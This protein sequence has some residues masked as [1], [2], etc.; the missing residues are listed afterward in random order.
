MV[1]LEARDEMPAWDY[2]VAD[3]LEEKVSIE[4]SFGPEE[5]LGDGT[6]VTGIRF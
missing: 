3:A 4:N 1:C 2:E 6:S 5:I